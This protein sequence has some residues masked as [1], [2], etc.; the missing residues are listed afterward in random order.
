M[1]MTSQMN[2]INVMSKLTD[3]LII[4]MKK[5]RKCEGEHCNSICTNTHTHT[6]RNIHAY[7]NNKRNMLC[8]AVMP[9]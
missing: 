4:T 5:K 6:K 9:I 8:Y 1:Q 2:M 3:K 7:V